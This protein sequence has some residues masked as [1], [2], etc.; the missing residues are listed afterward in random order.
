[1]NVNWLGLAFYW[2]TLLAYIY[3]V[4]LMCL[5]NILYIFV[6]GLTPGDGLEFQREIFHVHSTQGNVAGDIRQE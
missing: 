4:S 6:S 2:T 5:C 3:Y 1:M